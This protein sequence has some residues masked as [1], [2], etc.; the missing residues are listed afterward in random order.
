MSSPERSARYDE[1]RDEETVSDIDLDSGACAVYRWGASGMQAS[2]A[3][4][5]AAASLRVLLTWLTCATG[6]A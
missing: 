6:G 3:R 5:P 2:G 1:D 4:P